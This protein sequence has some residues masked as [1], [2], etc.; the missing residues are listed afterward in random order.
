[1]SE[2]LEQ[3]E[4]NN[5]NEIELKSY[6]Y[7]DSQQGEETSKNIYAVLLPSNNIIYIKHQIQ[8]QQVLIPLNIPLYYIHNNNF[9]KI[10]KD[11]KENLLYSITSIDEPLFTKLLFNEEL[12]NI[13]INS[14]IEDNILSIIINDNKNTYKIKIDDE[15]FINT[16]KYL[17]S[18]LA[19]A[20]Y[21][22]Y[23]KPILY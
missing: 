19:Y 18:I 9:L 17:G 11:S 7:Y 1:V 3:N 8:K 15:F 23:I 10:W 2:E 5:I 6:Y 20:L 12:F 14:E 13:K 16:N 22:L 21:I 4:N